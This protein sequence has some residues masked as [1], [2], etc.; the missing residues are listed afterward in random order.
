MDTCKMWNHRSSPFAFMDG[1]GSYNVIHCPKCRSGHWNKCSKTSTI[2]VNGIPL[3]ENTNNDI[4]ERIDL[5]KE[6]YH[7]TINAI[8]PTWLL[9]EHSKRDMKMTSASIKVDIPKLIKSVISSIKVCMGDLLQ[10]LPVIENTLSS[11]EFVLVD[12]NQEIEICKKQYDKQSK[13]ST[14]VI[15]KMKKSMKERR[16]FMNTFKSKKFRYT[17]EYYIFRPEN[18]EAIEVCDKFMNSN[19]KDKL[20]K[21]TEEINIQ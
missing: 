13:E 7:K 12:D 8:L 4:G 6:K 19:I 5:L 16:A 1:R 21:F 9:N 15:M 2:I 11:I 3:F 17:I 18:Q 14:Y 20:S 10:L